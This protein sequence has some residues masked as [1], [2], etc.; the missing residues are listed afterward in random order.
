MSKAYWLAG[1]AMAFSGC[2]AQVAVVDPPRPLDAYFVGWNAP[3]APF[4]IAGNLYYVG[5]RNV[6][7]YVLKTS[8]GLILLD[9]GFAQTVPQIATNLKALGMDMRQVKLI[10]TSHAHFDH[11]GGV[12]RVKADTG[13]TLAASAPDAALLARGGAGDFGG[14]GEASYAR[15]TADRIVRDGE[16]VTLGDVTLTAHVTPGHTRGCTTWSFRV[17]DG[18]VARDVVYFCGTSAPGYDLV[19]NAEYPEI[20]NDYRASFATMAALP[21]DIALVGHPQAID[22]ATKAERMRDGS[23]NPFVDRA[24]CNAYLDGQRAAFEREFAKQR[25]GQP[26]TEF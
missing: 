22:L 13:A 3:Q 7:A 24:G 21:C 12:A 25:S 14:D 5:A 1:L 9:T 23:D 10:I 6:A 4:R 2:S 18:G 15:V 20:A 16:R 11:A 8:D 19:D 26:P 17:N